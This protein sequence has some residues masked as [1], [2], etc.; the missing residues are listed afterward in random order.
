MAEKREKTNTE[1]NQ[2]KVTASLLT[3]KS[4]RKHRFLYDHHG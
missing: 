2:N 3:S 4:C 1:Q